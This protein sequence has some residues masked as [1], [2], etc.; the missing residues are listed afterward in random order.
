MHGEDFNLIVSFIDVVN[1]SRTLIILIFR[2]SDIIGLLYLSYC[3]GMK[4]FN[5]RRN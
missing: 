5:E 1:T 4:L 3:L 2:L